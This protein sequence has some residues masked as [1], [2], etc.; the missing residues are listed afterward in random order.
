MEIT[1]YDNGITRE[2]AFLLSDDSVELHEEFRDADDPNKWHEIKSVF[3][4]KQQV[5]ASATLFFGLLQL[6]VTD[7]CSKT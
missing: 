6:S 1:V 5:M 4:N 2:R 7:N 3:L